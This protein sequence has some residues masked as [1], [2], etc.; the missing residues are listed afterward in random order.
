MFLIIHRVISEYDVQ[1]EDTLDEPETNVDDY[2]EVENNS[3]QQPKI[4]TFLK[5]E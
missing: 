5:F 2:L 4:L 1:S 3:W